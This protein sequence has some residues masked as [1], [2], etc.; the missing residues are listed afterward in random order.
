MEV[1]ALLDR[2]GF[3]SMRRAVPRT[4]V[5]R[6]PQVVV[7]MHW[8]LLPA[9]LLLRRLLSSR[10]VYDEHDHYEMLALES[11]GPDRVKRARSWCVGRVHRWSLPRVD[12]VTCVHLAGG[13]LEAHLEQWATT[14]VEL[15][16]YPSRRWGGQGSGARSPDRSTAIVYV[17]GVWKEKGCAAMLD[18]F[19]LLADDR[20]PNPLTLHV[21]GEGDPDLESRLLAADGVTFHGTSAFD[22]IRRFLGDH[23]CLGLVLLEG[24]PRY[25]LAATNCQKLYEYLATGTPVLV[26]NV[27]EIPNVVADLGG[28][29]VIDAGFE[30]EELAG[31]LRGIV[32]AP[33]KRRRR[34][35]AAAE[36]I[37]REALWWD[38]EWDKVVRTGV[39]GPVTGRRV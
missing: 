39:L 36:A 9:A 20:S 4:R 15:H 18:A 24:T 5:P 34:G 22:V 1:P 26:T 35:Q 3:L 17:G 27:G 8:S 23:D 11:R 12:V 28:G 30:V 33:E 31:S 32:A 29:W 13:R 19:L 16:N 7:C 21:F 2:Q 37:E 10:L 6:R 25:S 38:V 14:V